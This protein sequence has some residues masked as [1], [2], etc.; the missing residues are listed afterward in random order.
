MRWDTQYEP[1]DLPGWIP[2]FAL[3][4][5]GQLLIE[6]KMVTGMD[7][8]LFQETAEK[9]QRSGWNGECLIV[10]DRL[11]LSPY[12]NLCVGW[13]GELGENWSPECLIGNRRWDFAPFNASFDDE[14]DNGIVGF[15]HL[16]G[17]WGDR[18][19]GRYDKTQ[20]LE[21]IGRYKTIEKIKQFWNKAGNEVQWHP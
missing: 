1:S 8:P 17:Y 11:P 10:S 21:H 18:V 15:S 2:D 4:G 9:I 5:Q 20:S 19:T 13:L 12:Q 14:D 6:V 3:N 16:S 7:D